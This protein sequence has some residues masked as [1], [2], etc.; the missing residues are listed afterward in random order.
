MYQNN[1]SSEPNFCATNLFLGMQFV[2]VTWR[3]T[4]SVTTLN[5][6][7]WTNVYYN[8]FFF[9]WILRVNKMKPETLNFSHNNENSKPNLWGLNVHCFVICNTEINGL[10]TGSCKNYQR[11]KEYIHTEWLQISRWIGGLV[12][13]HSGHRPNTLI[14][15]MR[16]KTPTYLRMVT[17]A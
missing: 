5:T 8:L 7:C 12:T 15:P 13:F 1:E 11:Q 2:H 4:Y 6:Q 17:G 3:P 9:L 16:N 14:N 10:K